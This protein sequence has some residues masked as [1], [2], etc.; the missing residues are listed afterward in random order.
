M[1]CAFV[2]IHYAM[3]YVSQQFPIPLWSMIWS[4]TNPIFVSKHNFVVVGVIAIGWWQNWVT[5]WCGTTPPS[6]Q[7]IVFFDHPNPKLVVMY[8]YNAISWLVWCTQFHLWPLGLACYYCGCRL[9]ITGRG[10]PIVARPEHHAIFSLSQHPISCVHTRLYSSNIC[11]FSCIV[12]IVAS[13]VG[14]I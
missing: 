14:A 6:Q 4:N 2:N 8:W 12:P 9:V 1:L 3:G 11:S 10:S 5:K 13:L 7:H